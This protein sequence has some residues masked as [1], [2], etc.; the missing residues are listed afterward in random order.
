MQIKLL[1]LLFLASTAFLRSESY[2][3]P[4]PRRFV[5]RSSLRS[6][7]SAS[8]LT[9]SLTSFDPSLTVSVPSNLTL[10]QTALGN[11][12][13]SQRS[14]QLQTLCPFTRTITKLLTYTYTLTKSLL[15]PPSIFLSCLLTRLKYTLTLPSPLPHKLIHKIYISR[16]DSLNILLPPP[17]KK[18]R[19]NTQPVLDLRPHFAM[20]SR[21]NRSSPK[22]SPR[23]NQPNLTSNL[24]TATPLPS[25]QSFD[26]PTLG[27][28]S[29]IAF[30]ALLNPSASSI[31][32]GSGL[33]QPK[34]SCLQTLKSTTT[35]LTFST[36]PPPQPT[37]SPTDFLTNLA[38]IAP[39]SLPLSYTFI[40]VA[41]SSADS[42]VESAYASLLSIPITHDPLFEAYVASFSF[43]TWIA[44][45]SFY[46]FS[47]TS[48]SNSLTWLKNAHE[49][50]NPLASYLGS[51]YVYHQ[52]HPHPALPETAP[53]L[54][55]LTLELTFGIFLYDFLM[56]WVHYLMHESAWSGHRYHHRTRGKDIEPVE[57]VQHG[58]LDGAAQVVVNVIVQ[59]ISPFG[60]GNKHFLSRLLHNILVTY[61]LTES[62]SGL[63]EKWMTHRLY[64]NLFGGA[65]R[66]QQ[67]HER[68]EGFYQ[69]FF[70]YLDDWRRTK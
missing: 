11:N 34:L 20:S 30:S 39:L 37:D 29:P 5:T 61:L 28:A 9:R 46:K 52:F 51:I 26:L 12:M 24:T 49:W 62:H 10:N 69:Q 4:L 27:P 53:S 45:L 47:C 21:P 38:R 58:Y 35:S 19:T 67:H 42:L 41:H 15:L 25:T 57:T 16:Q 14:L 8:E 2:L 70:M 40:P 17:E 50:F 56:Y 59:Q 18:S 54:G 23:S 48:S 55:T 36:S 1:L 22:S 44:L 6:S 64:P 63:D 43:V 33:I 31:T 13:P 3:N 65:K 60:F 68:G 32:F 66:H 7:D